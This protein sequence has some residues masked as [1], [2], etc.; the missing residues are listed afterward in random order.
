M[1][2]E[3][4]KEICP[5]I[6]TKDIL[7]GLWIP[8]DG[9]GKS[10]LVCQS[11]MKEAQRMGVKVVENCSVKQIVQDHGKV[12]KIETGL[13][14]IDCT[15]FVNCAGFW[16]RNV[17]EMSSPAVKVP[18]H[19]AEHY[20]LHTKIIESLDKNTPIVRDLDSN[21]YLREIDGRILAGGFEVKAK[22][23]FDDG[24]FPSK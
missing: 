1:N 3:Q 17:G 16:A 2:P 7:G 22:P 15:Y 5:I 23:A 9:V 11:L 4:C 8:E 19:P 6:D 14:D 12:S 20:Y 21:I 18:I 13:G 24:A 10:Y